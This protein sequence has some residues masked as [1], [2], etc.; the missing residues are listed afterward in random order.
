M[1][2]S[3][4]TDRQFGHPIAA[5]EARSRRPVDVHVHGAPAGAQGPGHRGQDGA[6]EEGLREPAQPRRRA[7]PA[8]L[9]AQAV[10]PVQEPAVPVGHLQVSKANCERVALFKL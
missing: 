7:T 9:Q 5:P 3:Q 10:L 8:H 4:R 1:F 2:L 6:L